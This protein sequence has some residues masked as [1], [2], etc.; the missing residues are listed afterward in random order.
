ME[1]SLTVRSV[2][3]SEALDLIEIRLHDS[4]HPATFLD[5]V[6]QIAEQ[7]K[8]LVD[9]PQHIEFDAPLRIGTTHKETVALDGE[10]A[11]S[12]FEA[13]GDIDRANA[14]DPRLWTYLSVVALRDYMVVRWPISDPESFRS[15]VEDHWLMTTSSPRK[16]MRNGAARLWWTAA[17]THDPFLE[18]RLSSEN[19]DPFAYTK[20]V[21]ANENR[22]QSIF[23]RRIGRSPKL[24]WAV[25]EAMEEIQ[26]E[27]NRE[28]SKSSKS[29]MKKVFLHSGYQRLEALPQEELNTVIKNLMIDL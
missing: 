28:S 23:E 19:G 8:Y 6:D 14:S 21:L 27:G 5:H 26:S 9:L 18:K 24:R 3:T 22:R 16:M 12:L 10:N 4:D 20:W 15:R 13:V 17:L 1:D 29:M 11:S 7:T 25:I 2:F